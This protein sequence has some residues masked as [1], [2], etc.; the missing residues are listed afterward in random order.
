VSKKEKKLVLLL[1]TRWNFS[2]SSLS[3]LYLH[4]FHTRY[5]SSI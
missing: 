3:T 2:H 5:L 4:F 1:P